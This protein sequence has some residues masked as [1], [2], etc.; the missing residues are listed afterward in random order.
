[1]GGIAPGKELVR[2]QGVTKTFPPPVSGAP[3]VRVLDEVDLVVHGGEL[4]LVQGC[5][6]SGKSTLLGL[7]GLLWRPTRGRVF[8]LGQEVSDDSS[9]YRNRLRRIH[10][11]FIFQN[12]HLF[13]RM[14]AW[15]SVALPLRVLGFS[16]AECRRRAEEL[17]ARLDL[18][19]RANHR[20]EQLS[21]GEQ[22]RVAVARA[23][24]TAPDLV[25]ADEPLSNADPRSAEL[26][27]SLLIMGC[28][29]G[30][31]LLV[32]SHDQRFRNL[33]ARRLEL[34]IPDA[35]QNGDFR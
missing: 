9:A 23:L 30:S 26:I 29:S 7:A 28:S 3:G 4:A 25:I 17:L 5:S 22:Q 10:V 31:G 32:A 24:S 6:G 19:G 21:G 8:F 18:E 11:G 1:M 13:E 35:A 14:P 27:V 34:T 33:A 2:L 16:G 12:Y 15:E 20:S